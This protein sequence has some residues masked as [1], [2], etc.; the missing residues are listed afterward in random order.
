MKL[1]SLMKKE[2]L[3]F[4]RDPRLIITMLLPGVAIYLL[5]S[6]MGSVM[7]N[8][9]KTQ[10]YEVYVSGSSIALIQIDAAVTSMEGTVTFTEAEDLEEAKKGVKDG[11]ATALIVFSENFDETIAEYNG[12]VQAYA[13]IYYRSAD[14]DSVAFYS[15]ASGVLNGYQKQFAVAYNDCSDEQ[16]ILASVMGN[17]LPFIVIALIFSSC[18]SVTLESIA[19][20]KE[21]G[22]L[23][24]ILVTPVKR[25]HIALGKVI[26]LSCIALLGATSSYL[27]VILSLP[28][29]VGMN[30]GGIMGGYGFLSYLLLLLLIFS[31]VPVIVAVIAAVS[32]YARSV[33]EAT[34]YTSF[35]M[36][37]TMVFSL[38]ASFI[39]GIG[40]WISVVPVLNAVVCMQNILSMSFSVWQTVVSI[41]ANLAYT[42]VLLFAISKMLSSEKIMFGK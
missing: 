1:L 18:M 23:A 28:K 26:P 41:I 35:V 22:T 5:Y 10:E 25:Y 31:L 42:A 29:L 15:I 40:G 4:F 6:V 17:V 21:R 14:E 32:T 34:A 2:F 19:G 36:I 11:D 12:T 24:T 3:R 37:F 39:S 38:V 8:T 13:E 20:E 16:S 9:K 27:G 7:W 33:K 30:V